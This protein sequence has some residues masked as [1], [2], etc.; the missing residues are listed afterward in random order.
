MGPGRSFLTL[1]GNVQRGKRSKKVP[2]TG[3]MKRGVD[4]TKYF[5]TRRKGEGKR[6]TAIDGVRAIACK[7]LSGHK[8]ELKQN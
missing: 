5:E 1:T 3:G 6:T 7:M 8:V 4:L 2:E